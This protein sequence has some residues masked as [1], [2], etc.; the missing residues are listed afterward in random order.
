MKI[1]HY[2]KSDSLYIKLSGEL[3]EHCSGYARLTLDMLVEQSGFGK[4]YLDMS[5]LSF[6][7]STGIGVLI[8]RY[9]K[10]KPRGICM[11]IMS[12]TPAVDRVLEISGI[13]Q[14]MS[15]AG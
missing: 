6:M 15:K 5:E 10:L 2:K 8:G 4:I 9:K 13:Y 11:Y 3:D 1:E 12:P 14:I 7:D